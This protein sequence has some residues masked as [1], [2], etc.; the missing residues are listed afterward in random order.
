MLVEGR[1]HRKAILRYSS[2]ISFQD[3]QS[4]P[5]KYLLSMTLLTKTQ[6]EVSC[7]VAVETGYNEQ[8][9]HDT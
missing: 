9:F 4:V 6:I 5:Q 2:T 7:D 3:R 1:H 8:L